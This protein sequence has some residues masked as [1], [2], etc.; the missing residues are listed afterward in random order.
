MK[1]NVSTRE[2]YCII[3]RWVPLFYVSW[4]T[5]FLLDVTR[6]T[7][8]LRWSYTK[9]FQ[10]L[11]FFLNE[12]FNLLP[13]RQR[14]NNVCSTGRRIGYVHVMINGY[15]ITDFFIQSYTSCNIKIHRCNY[16]LNYNNINEQ[17][18]YYNHIH[19]N[20]NNGTYIELYIFAILYLT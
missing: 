11:N 1:I 18:I 8:W 9:N 20:S 17:W 19:S 7:I 16:R 2:W 3:S 15:L 12:F 14:E 6:V 10:K 4:L 5:I 13:N